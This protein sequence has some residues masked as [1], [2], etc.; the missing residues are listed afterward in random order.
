MMGG[1]VTTLPFIRHPQTGRPLA[2]IWSLGKT[3]RDHKFRRQVLVGAGADESLLAFGNDIQWGIAM[4]GL[5][6]HNDILVK[7]DVDEFYGLAGWRV[8]HVTTTKMYANPA[9]MRDEVFRFLSA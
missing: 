1:R 6:Y 2:I 9:K 4:D 5:R 7:Q 8:L 3:L